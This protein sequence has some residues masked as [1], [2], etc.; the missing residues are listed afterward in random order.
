MKVKN[1]TNSSDVWMGMTIVDGSEY[2]VGQ[3]ELSGWR[4]DSKVMAD[5]SSLK[6]L[7]HDGT[8]YIT[9]AAKAVAHF[10]DS[11]VAQV[12]VI[13][14]TPFAEPS[15]RTKRDKTPS[16]VTVSPGATE[17]IDFMLTQERYVT[18]GSMAIEGS[19]MGDYVSAEIYD[20]DSIIPSPYRDALCESWPCVAKY[21]NGQWVPKSVT[22]MEINTYP[23]SAK[24]SAGL[25]LRVTYTASQA[26]SS[27]KVGVTYF[28]NKKL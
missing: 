9:D 10:L 28:L 24:V 18:G 8:S 4:A 14:Q 1:N 13:S 17:I 16:I 11:A 19:E 12:S 27:R 25:Y 23:L 22:H 5:I 21:I 3:S 15:F 26:G 20:K 6:L 7:V 2:V